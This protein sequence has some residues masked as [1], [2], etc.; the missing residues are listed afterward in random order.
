MKFTI[1]SVPL[2]IAI[3]IGHNINLAHSGGLDGKTY[4]DHT[5]LMGNPLY[6]DDIGA[7]CFNAA[8]NY[9]L[10]WYDSNTIIIN[11]R[12]GDW[13]GKIV[14]IADFAN[15]PDD[16]PV[17]IKIETGT[18]I[19]QFIAF[20]RATGINRH[21]D[22]ADNEVTI[23]EAG[24]NGEW[25]S[26]SFLKATLRSGEVY[27]MP[28]WDGTHTLTITAQSININTGSAAGYAIVSVCLGPCVYPSEE[29]S[30]KPTTS[31]TNAPTHSPTSSPTKVPTIEPTAP[32]T[33]TPTHSPTSSPTK[34]PTISPT[35]SPVNNPKETS[36]VY[37]SQMGIDIDGSTTQ[38]FLGKSVSVSKDGLRMA[39]AATGEQGSKGVTRAFQWNSNIDEW[40]QLGQDIVGT[41]DNDGL[42][43]SMDMNED[44]SRIILGAPEA[45]SDDGIVRVYELDDSNTWQLL[46]SDI[47][48]ARG[49][50]GQAGFSVTM[51]ASGD[52]VAYG[53]PRMNNY[54]GQVQAFELVRG[55]WI[56][57]GQDIN[58]F[59]TFSYSGG[60]IS[61]SADGTR[62]V[63]GSEEG[64]YVGSAKVYDFDGSQWQENG[65]I[66]GRYY[67]D[68]FGGAVDISEDGSRIIVGARTSDG[69]KRPRGV[70]NAG[71]FQVFEYDGRD[72]NVI[73]QKIIGSAASDK[74]GESVSISGDGTTIAISSPN[75]DENGNNAGKV[76]VYK[77]SEVD[78]TWIPQGQDILGECEKDRL[79]EG[80]SSIALDR[81]GNHLAVG[82]IRANYYSGMARVFETVA[83]EWHSNIFASNDNCDR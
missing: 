41:N 36:H 5:G 48:I 32:P 47:Q 9:Q 57:M 50:G 72:W 55:Q 35:A 37:Y 54:A 6:S 1:Q 75:N 40:I 25:Y 17:V 63:V 64:Y 67:Y 68:R 46:G 81:S 11:P 76:E 13:I 18:S 33:N 43:W 19:D 30:Q 78:D 29:P 83:G 74:L 28:Q 61:M 77:Y 14:G 56:P 12:D 59:D 21:N 60:S 80:G 51:N 44:G 27:T 8:K 31:P 22:E 79:G 65:S 82:A 58:P 4:T 45:N 66:S 49:S 2:F 62:I 3:E 42:G 38:G 20:N 26:Q 39:I 70:F 7:M 23:V 53:A 10:P 16:S 73:G 71:E 69:M 34:V 15:N 52:I 24:N